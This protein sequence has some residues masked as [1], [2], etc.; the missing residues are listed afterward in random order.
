MIKLI[1][2]KESNDFL[3]ILL[4]SLKKK[5]VISVDE[6][7][8]DWCEYVSEKWMESFLNFIDSL[9]CFDIGTIGDY[10]IIIIYKNK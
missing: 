7:K 6:F 4:K 8:N 2:K 10:D 5:E 3:R 9:E 1:I